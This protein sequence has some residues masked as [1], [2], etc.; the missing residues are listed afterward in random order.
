[1]IVG[2]TLSGGVGSNSYLDDAFMLHPN[3][4]LTI[5]IEDRLVVK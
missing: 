5:V 4:S 1:M 3:Y 2:D